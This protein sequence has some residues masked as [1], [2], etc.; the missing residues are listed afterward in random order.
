MFAGSDGLTQPFSQTVSTTPA[1]TTY[2]GHAALQ[3]TTTATGQKIQTNLPVSAVFTAVGASVFGA[4]NQIVSDFANG[5]SSSTLQADTALPSTALHG[6]V[7][8]RSV[9][10]NSLA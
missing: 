8:Q 4:L 5:A 1:T 6:V 9:L 10:D 3:Y 7:S 2:N